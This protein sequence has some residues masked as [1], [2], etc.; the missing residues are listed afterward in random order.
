M[1]MIVQ[2]TEGSV[3]SGL[4]EEE[5]DLKSLEEVPIPSL[6]SLQSNWVW[7]EEESQGQ[8]AF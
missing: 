7:R 6:T 8:A 5:E 4:K 3:S 1:S 2:E